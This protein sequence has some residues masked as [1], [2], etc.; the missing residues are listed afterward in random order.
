MLRVLVLWLQALPV[1]A[2]TPR[3]PVWTSPAPDP[4]LPLGGYSL[5]NTKLELIFAATNTSGTYNHNLFLHYHPSAD[6]LFGY[7]KN[8]PAEEDTPGQRILLSFRRSSTNST[9]SSSSSSSLDSQ[10]K[11]SSPVVAFGNLSTVGRETVMFGAPGITL[12][13]GHVYIAASP[14]F[15]NRSKADV[16]VAQGAQCALWPDSIDT[17]NC[18]PAES[19]AVL[20]HSTLLLRRVYA[21][22]TLGPMFWG[23][24]PPS[25]FAAATAKYKIPS[26]KDLDDELQQD[27]AALLQYRNDPDVPTNVPCGREYTKTTKCEWCAGGCQQFIEIDYSLGITNERSTYTTTDGVDV[28]LYR[29]RSGSPLLAST[30]SV[31]SGPWTAVVATNIPNDASNLNT[32]RLSN[33]LRYMVHNPVTRKNTDEDEDRDP[34]TLTTSV[35][36]WSWNETGVVATCTSLPIGGCT[37]RFQHN[38]NTGPSYPQL[39]EIV[40]EGSQG[41]WIGFSNNKEDVWVVKIVGS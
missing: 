1:L 25:L 9:S 29:G 16:H 20:Y 41:V 7:W 8:A 21:N 17:R 18:G 4:T 10:S 36:G 32:G 39:I 30:R 3:L 27:V 6:R 37:P 13:N 33:G 19:Y 5:I 2:A 38:V 12:P 24:Q 23:I 22:E 31:Q 11:W 40:K 14:G 26:V 35:D 15:Y 28:L 34:L